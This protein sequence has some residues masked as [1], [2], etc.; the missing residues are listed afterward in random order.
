LFLVKILLALGILTFLLLKVDFGRLVNA[1]EA[2]LGIWLVLALSSSSLMLVVSALKWHVLLRG[3]HVSVTRS[4]L[5]AV[6]TIGF[7]AS[8]LLPGVVGGDVV[9]WSLT[10]QRT[11]HHVKIAAT[12]LAERVT[13][14]V[15]LVLI[16]V[17][18]VLGGV[19]ELGV[20]P[21][22]ALIGAVAAGL[23][24]GIG[25]ALNRRLAATIA[26]LSR[27]QRVLGRITSALYMVHRTL[28]RFP[29]RPIGVAL[30][31]SVL[32]YGVGGFSFYFICRAFSADVSAL[33]AVA[34]QL[35]TSLVTLVPISIGGL[36]LAQ[37]GDV[38]FLDHLGVG[39]ATALGISMARAL[40]QLFYAALGGILFVRWTPYRCGGGPM[41][42]GLEAGSGSEG[43]MLGVH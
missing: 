19:P 16:S 33:E 4:F 35:L 42:S 18:I 14:V 9:R 36:G 15:A 26:F 43:R 2:S 3:V 11:G 20:L 21:V 29:W 17:P 31:Y 25:V 22:V 24:I 28:R 12:I 6:Y 39:L 40:V 7:F 10:G 27:R 23:A 13:G 5:L 30:G 41:P 34:V 1:V 37:A 38:Y 32:F 8:S